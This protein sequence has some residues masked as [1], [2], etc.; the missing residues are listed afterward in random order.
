M[1]ALSKTTN[2][3]PKENLYYAI[4]ELA[5]AIARSDGKVQPAERKKLHDILIKNLG[6]QG[7]TGISEIIFTLMDKKE[8][9]DSETTYNW[10]IQ[11]IRTNS[12]YLSPQMKTSFLTIL[13]QVAEA[14]PPV[15]VEEQGYINR[16]K[17]DIAPLEGDPIFYKD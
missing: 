10:A 13:E 14:F 6:R 15:S 2:M 3:S 9:F 12:H 4:G 7:E 16:F 8:H 11:E 5:Y 17:K 1:K